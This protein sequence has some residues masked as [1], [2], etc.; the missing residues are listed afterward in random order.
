AVSLLDYYILN[1]NNDD[2]SRYKISLYNDENMIDINTTGTAYSIHAGKEFGDTKGIDLAHNA[3]DFCQSLKQYIKN[4][5]IAIPLKVKYQKRIL[6]LI[7]RFKESTEATMARMNVYVDGKLIRAKIL[8]KIK[9]IKDKN[10]ITKIDN[11]KIESIEMMDIFYNLAHNIEPFAY[12][13]ERNSP[14]SIGGE[15]KLR[16]PEGRYEVRWRK[17]SNFGEVLNLGNDYVSFDRAILI[18][19]GKTPKNSDGCLLIG[20]KIDMNYISGESMA[21]LLAQLIKIKLAGA[22]NNLELRIINAFTKDKQ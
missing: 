17:S 1:K 9:M 2:V 21:K 12:I 8:G 5:K 15:L 20:N 11:R 10:K 7:E 16:V 4:T 13:L 6:I 18:H 19:S 3:K 14:D 22:K